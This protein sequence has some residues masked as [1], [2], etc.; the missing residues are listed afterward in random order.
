MI[1]LYLFLLICVIIIVS[2]VIY[3][4]FY[5][6]KIN[7]ILIEQNT[8]KKSNA[9]LSPL[10]FLIITLISAV[11]LYLIVLILLAVFSFKS[12]KGSSSSLNMNV[13]VYLNNKCNVMSNFSPDKKISGYTR[14]EEIDGNIRLVQYVSV[15]KEVL[16]FPKVLIYM[17][18]IGNDF[19]IMYGYNVEFNYKKN[20]IREEN[21][22]SSI[23]DRNGIWITIPVIDD[24][25]YAIFRYYTIKNE[26]AHS[27][28]D[29]DEE[30]KLSD[31]CGEFK[32]DFSKLVSI[33]ELS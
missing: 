7:R 9:I 23:N 6:H 11:I 14:E 8:K 28:M 20:Y 19:D 13:G 4:V 3:M 25:E 21:F 1:Y 12:V 33:S 5:K 10:N 31:E 32:I 26:N 17:E 29:S 27:A 22:S 18:Y 16:D 2:N 15:S 24:N 30:Y